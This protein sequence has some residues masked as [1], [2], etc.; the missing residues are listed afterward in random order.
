M[1]RDALF[2]FRTCVAELA[3]RVRTRLDEHVDKETGKWGANMEYKRRYTNPDEAKRHRV[4]P[5]NKH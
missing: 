5:A 3:A 1:F 2:R 4:P